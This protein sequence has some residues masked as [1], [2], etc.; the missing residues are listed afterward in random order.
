LAR[1]PIGPQGY[2]PDAP[3]R[4]AGSS[5]GLRPGPMAGLITCG[6]RPSLF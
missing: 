6:P 5:V 4:G 3:A 2:V 1:K